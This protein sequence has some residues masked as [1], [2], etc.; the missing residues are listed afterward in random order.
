[1][2]CAA[3]HS[4]ILQAKMVSLGIASIIHS[5]QLLLES[6]RFPWRLKDA[7]LLVFINES[8]KRLSL[9]AA[10]YSCI[11]IIIEIFL[12]N[13]IYNNFRSYFS[14]LI[15]AQLENSLVRVLSFE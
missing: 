2:S 1:M 14:S 12:I 6:F 10:F 8:L 5:S 9:Q 3:T 15:P 11:F 13:I 4:K 7:S